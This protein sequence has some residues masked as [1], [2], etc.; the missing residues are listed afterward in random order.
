MAHFIQ[1]RMGIYSEQY[2][3]PTMFQ[4]TDITFIMPLVCISIRIPYPWIIIEILPKYC[5]ISFK[6]INFDR[7]N[8][9]CDV[10]S[11]TGHNSKWFET[12]KKNCFYI[13]KHFHHNFQS[14][15]QTNDYVLPRKMRCISSFVGYFAK[16][17]YTFT[18]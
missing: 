11:N 8:Y 1:S 2:P 14:N 9:P 13:P 15:D 3:K 6:Q 18:L 16:F 17:S 5:N 10:F 12:K 7:R 4:K